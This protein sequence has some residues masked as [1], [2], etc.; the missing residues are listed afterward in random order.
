[1]ENKIDT[2]LSNNY[3]VLLVALDSE[4]DAEITYKTLIEYEKESEKP[5]QEILDL[6]DK[7][8]KDELEHIAL[9]SALQAKDNSKY[10][11]EDAEEDFS[12]YVENTEI[13]E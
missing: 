8:L 4:K 2:S 11:G 1:M 7:I 13:E 12:D 9:L 10:V 6:L 5:R 3:P